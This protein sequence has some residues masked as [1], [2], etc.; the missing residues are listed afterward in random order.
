ME[1]GDDLT[2]VGVMG[3][4]G[5]FFLSPFLSL[6]VEVTVAIVSFTVMSMDEIMDTE[7]GFMA[8]DTFTA[9]ATTDLGEM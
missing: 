9:D 2:T 6:L 7:R 5:E 3:E 8:V 1:A 4:S